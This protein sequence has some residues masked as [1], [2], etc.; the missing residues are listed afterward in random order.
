VVK[1]NKESFIGKEA[2]LRQKEEGLKRRRVGIK[3]IEKGIP[4]QHHKVYKNGEKIGEITS[5]TFAPFL[6]I[7]IG[8]AY[9]KKEYDKEGEEIKVKIRDKLL[10]AEIVKLPFYQRRSHDTVIIYGKKYPIEEA[11]KLISTLKT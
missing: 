7:G 6:K 11:R 9:V 2:L 1:F 3:M 5:G 4:R 10:K 8:M